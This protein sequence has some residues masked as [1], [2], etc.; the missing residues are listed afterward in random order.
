[1]PLVK[2]MAPEDAWGWYWQHR[3]ELSHQEAV[4]AQDTTFHMFVSFGAA[5][6]NI[7]P[8]VRFY[9]GEECAPHS[10]RTVTNRDDFVRVVNRYITQYLE[11]DEDEQV[12]S[13]APTEGPAE[14]AAEEKPTESEE[15]GEESDL[16]PE[17]EIYQREDQLI[18]AMSDFLAVVLCE[19]DGIAVNEAYGK[20]MVEECVDHILSFAFE[21]Y[22]LPIYRP[23]F[24]RDP[25]TNEVEFVEFPYGEFE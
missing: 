7:Y 10:V 3:N 6:N 19:D 12:E 20:K 21:E 15:D 13:S 9:S 16:T 11:D 17:E 2:H 25:K 5:D 14:E 24:L 1:M 8:E 22:N 18:C 23:M 4:L